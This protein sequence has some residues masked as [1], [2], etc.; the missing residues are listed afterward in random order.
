VDYFIAA[1]DA[2]PFLCLG[3]SHLLI[4]KLGFNPYI[5]HVNV[6]GMACTSFTK[7]LELAGD[8]L[9]MHPHDHVLLC[10]SG[11]NSYWL[12]NQLQ[13]WRDLMGIHEIRLMK[14]KSRQKVELRKWI[15][16]MEYFLFGEGVVSCVVAKEG[17]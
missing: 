14:N 6:H 1:Y 10:T 7:T 11:V 4:R 3:L 12:V 16:I 13:G 8:Y 17:G 9:A 2:N 15:A 5:K